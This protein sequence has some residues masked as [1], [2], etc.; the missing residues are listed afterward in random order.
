[1]NAAFDFAEP[2]PAPSAFIF[3]VGNPARAR[4]A[5][6]RAVALVMQGIVGNFMV[7]QVLPDGF[8]APIRHRVQFNDIPAR[9]LVEGIYFQ[10]SNGG[11]GVRLLAAQSRNP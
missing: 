7:V 6:N 3:S 5:T 11:A 9:G 8:F 1:M 4:L 2:G 10:D